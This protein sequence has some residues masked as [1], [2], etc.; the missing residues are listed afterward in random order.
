LKENLAALSVKLSVQDV[1]E[2]NAA[3]K[4]ANLPSER[5]GKGMLELVLI[6]TPPL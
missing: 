5:Y 4:E 3:V 1:Q 6:D 2:I